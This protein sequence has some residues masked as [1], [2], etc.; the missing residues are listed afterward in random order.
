[1]RILADCGLEISSGKTAKK[2]NKAF[3]LD[4]GGGAGG[5]GGGGGF[6]KFL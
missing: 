3:K 5:G 1:M 4:R 6:L 2:D